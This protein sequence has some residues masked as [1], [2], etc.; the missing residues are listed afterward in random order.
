MLDEIEG[1][2]KFI[3]ELR[4]R[5]NDPATQEV[6]DLQPLF[7]RG[8][9]LF[10]IEFESIEYTSNQGMTNVIRKIF[11]KQDAAGSLLRPEYVIRPDATSASLTSPLTPP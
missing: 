6:Q 2:L 5:M 7:E 9:W 11:G 1:R 8:L 4:R 10:G 3:H